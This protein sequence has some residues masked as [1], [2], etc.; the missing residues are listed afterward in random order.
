MFNLGAVS[1]PMTTAYVHDIFPALDISFKLASPIQSVGELQQDTNFAIGGTVGRQAQ[2]VPLRI[3]LLDAGKKINRKFNVRVIKDPNFTPQIA[4]SIA[5]DALQ[6]TLGLDSDKMVKIAFSMGLKNGPAIRRLNT[7][8]ASDQVVA[9]ALGEMFDALS[10]TQANG[11]EKGNITSMDLR[12]EVTGA[13]RTARIRRIYADKNRLKAGESAQI[14]VVLE[15]TG[16]PDEQVTRRFTVRVP[17]DAPSGALRV[18]ASSGAEIF[19]A[20]AR[21]GGEPPRPGNFKELLGAYAQIGSND[22]L[23][24]QTSTP[25]RFLLIDRKRVSNP[26]PSWNRLVPSGPSS[27]VSLF[28]ETQSQKMKSEWVLSGVESLSIPVESSRAS[29]KTRPDAPANEDGSP[30]LSGSSD[31]VS[32][33]LS[34]GEDSFLARLPK[35]EELD[36]APNFGA[37]WKQLSRVLMQIPAPKPEPPVPTEPTPDPKSPIAP[38][39]KVAPLTGASPTPA[40]P[41][42]TATPAPDAPADAAAW[43]I[44]RPAGRF[45]QKTSADFG[46]G[47]FDGTL[48][49]SDNIVRVGPRNQRLF[50]S[51][52]PLAWSIAADGKGA[53]YLGTGNSA[54][55]LKIENG[56]SKVLYEGPEVAVTALALDKNGILYAGVS[57]GGRVLRF[58]ADGTHRVVLETGQTFVHALKFDDSENLF[59]ATGGERAKIYRLA[60]PD[61]IVGTSN[62]IPLLSEIPIIGMRSRRR[63]QSDEK[64]V[65]DLSQKHARSLTISGDSI[66]VGTSEDAVLYR[67]DKNGKTTALYQAGGAASGSASGDEGGAIY[68]APSAPTAPG[69]PAAPPQAPVTV[70]SAPGGYFGGG[71]GSGNEILSLAA[72]GEDV[73]FGTANS[74]SIFRWN[75]QS[76]VQE[77]FKTPGRAVYA[78][79]MQGDALFAATGESGE[80]WR[81]S[82]LGGDVQGARVLDA[83]QPQVMALAGANNRV[84]AATGN[85]AAA[86]EIGGAGDNSF[87]SN[88][89]DAGQIVRFGALTTLSSGAVFEFRSGNTLEPAATWSNWTKVPNGAPAAPGRARY[90]QYRAKLSESGTI[91]RVEIAFKAPNRAPVV[92]FTSPAGGEYFSGKK[93][94]SWSGTDADKDPLRYSLELVGADGKAQKIEL[95]TPT[96][97]TQEID[98]KK[99][100]DGIYTAKIAASDAARNPEEPLSD[101]AISLPF[102][103]DNSAPKAEKPL[104]TTVGAAWDVTF[105]SSD[106]ISSIAGA[107]WRVAANPT[108]NEGVAPKPANSAAGKAAVAKPANSTTVEGK[109]PTAVVAETANPT[110]NEAKPGEWQA[111][112]ALDGFFDGKTEKIVAHLDPGVAGIALKSGDVIEFRVRDAADNMISMTIA[113][114]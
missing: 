112:A 57:P 26:P 99:Y 105:G 46:R 84:F 23:L 94:L 111:A 71:Q 22:E 53:V 19:A 39:L 21:V 69:A 67:I 45:I 52:E 14:S 3:S 60:S 15:P 104:A 44:A 6:A 113:L 25:R 58:N 70:F 100:A 38:S 64:T 47:K 74:G 24:L 8:Y 96:A 77:L 49:G 42:P 80:V 68:V 75:A 29:D 93:T 98:T 86:Y 9:G 109:T 114:P 17:E 28:N 90:A 37:R 33:D 92:R 103:L 10:I 76:G 11:F 31:I 30:A 27:S 4:Q 66:F 13:R 35:M 85:N 110:K 101:S 82:N 20:R 91:S 12:V 83:A 65:I 106:S 87:V 54:R 88:V 7:V 63:A 61:A 36:A 79:Q 97:A 18:A 34:G 81:V 51:A 73:Y 95:T 108:K 16:Q 5:V 56:I 43:G 50:S 89:F 2:T 32:A 1:M 102:T 48:V 62:Q 107:E 40:A 59:V 78:L 72:T 41:A 55:L